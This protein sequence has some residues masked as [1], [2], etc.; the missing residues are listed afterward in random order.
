MN[1]PYEAQ[2]EAERRQSPSVAICEHLCWGAPS[3]ERWRQHG[4]GKQCQARL[5]INNPGQTH[6]PFQTAGSARL[7]AAAAAL[8][9]ATAAAP[10][11]P[12]SGLGKRPFPPARPPAPGRCRLQTCAGAG[13]GWPR[14]MRAAR[15]HRDWQTAARSCASTAAR[16]RPLTSAQQPAGPAAPVSAGA[17][18]RYQP[19]KV[20]AGF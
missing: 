13:Q 17:H 20:P 1:T 16:D 7:H 11:T 8:E 2:R 14:C 15:P 6:G 5:T 18:Q 19:R 9:T 12:E 3:F 4:H 10:A